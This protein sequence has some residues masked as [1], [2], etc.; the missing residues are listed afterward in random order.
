MEVS[1]G[2]PWRDKANP[3]YVALTEDSIEGQN[4]RMRNMGPCREVFYVCL[5]LQLSDLCRV[6]SETDS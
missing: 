4:V 6:E 3:L 2:H 1:V 5:Y